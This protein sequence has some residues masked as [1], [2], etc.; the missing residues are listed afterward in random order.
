MSVSDKYYEENEK[1]DRSVLG[2]PG[3]VSVLSETE[4]LRKRATG[5][6]QQGEVPARLAGSDLEM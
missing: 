4:W 1:Q 5:R 2:I 6:C 3:S